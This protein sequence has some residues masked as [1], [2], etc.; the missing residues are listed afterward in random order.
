MTTL[1]LIICT[2]ILTVF[3]PA[4]G[5]GLLFHLSFD[6]PSGTA[7]ATEQVSGAQFT[8][9]NAFDRPE[10]IYTNPHTCGLMKLLRAVMQGAGQNAAR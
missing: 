4:I 1:K 2:V 10:R 8:V 5:Q 9:R 6:E 3:A 7:T